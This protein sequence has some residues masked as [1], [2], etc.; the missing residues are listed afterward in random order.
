MVVNQQKNADYESDNVKDKNNLLS[1][2]LWSGGDYSHNIS[3]TE[4]ML[5]PGANVSVSNDYS[6]NYNYSIKITKNG[7]SSNWCRFPINLDNTLLGKTIN[8]SAMIYTPYADCNVHLLLMNGNTPVKT[9]ASVFAKNT[10]FGL[11]ELS[12]VFYVSAEK[13]YFNI[14]VID[15]SV[16]VDNL[17]CTIL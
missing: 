12:S 10:L 14:Q 2:A 16:Y 1:H 9:I 17:I 11:V 3:N 15:G 6:Y 8:L 5:G 4:Y 13:V 7:S